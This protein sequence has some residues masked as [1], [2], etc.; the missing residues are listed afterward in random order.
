MFGCWSLSVFVVC[1]SVVLPL[2]RLFFVACY[3]LRVVVRCLLFVVF[4]LLFDVV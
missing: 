4:C 3:V 1:S 2:R